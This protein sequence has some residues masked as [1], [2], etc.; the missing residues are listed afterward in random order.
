MT[1]QIQHNP[2]ESRFEAQ[3]DGHLCVADYHLIGDVMVM[4]HTYV[5]AAVQGRG[6]AAALVAQA[7]AHARAQRLKVDPRCSYVRS[8]MQRHPDTLSLQA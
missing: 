3:V 7:L 5:P 8:Y 4:P 6:I 1:I 2:K